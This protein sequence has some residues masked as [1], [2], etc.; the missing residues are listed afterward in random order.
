M[1]VFF[2][3]DPSSTLLQWHNDRDGSLNIFVHDNNYSRSVLKCSQM[4]S[5]VE[6]PLASKNKKQTKTANIKFSEHLQVFP[7][8]KLI[9][10]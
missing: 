9:L 1:L 10:P 8:V 4:P 2:R 3:P 7:A 6:T 5:D